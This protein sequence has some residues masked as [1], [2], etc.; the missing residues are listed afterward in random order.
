MKKLVDENLYKNTIVVFTSDNGPWLPYDTHGGSA[1][2]L[3]EGKGTT[4]EGGHRVPG[5]FWGGSIK[6]GTISE[7]GSTMDL[8]TTF[9]DFADIDI[10]NDRV[11]DGFSLKNTLINH[12][13]GKRNSI[14]FYRQREIYAARLND[15]KAHFITEGAY[16]YNVSKYYNAKNYVM[17]NKKRVLKT[18]LLFNL[19]E[20]PSEKYDIADEN[21]DII[22]KIIELVEKHKKDLNAPADLLSSRTEN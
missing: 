11:I 17:N 20:D 10:P 6:S 1:G 9:L 15:Y 3:R 5:L 7:L 21:P 16:E 13:A 12:G 22:D 18:P 4:W 8:Y 2:L 19:N 14:L